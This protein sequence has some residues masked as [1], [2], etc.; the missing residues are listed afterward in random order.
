MF[1]DI[2]SISR[3]FAEFQVMNTIITLE[4]VVTKY[5]FITTVTQ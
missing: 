1:I 4:N 3:I 5:T 2:I